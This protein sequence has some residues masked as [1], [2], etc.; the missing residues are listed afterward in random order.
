MGRRIRITL[1][2]AIAGLL[3]AAFAAG[4]AWAAGPTPGTPE[5]V[6]RDNQNMTDA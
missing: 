2:F 6:Q 3:T 4:S 5:Y 1:A